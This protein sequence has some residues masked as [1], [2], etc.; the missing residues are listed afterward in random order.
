MERAAVASWSRKGQERAFQNKAN[1]LFTEAMKT[2]SARLSRQLS[3]PLFSSFLSRRWSLI[4]QEVTAP[5]LLSLSWNVSLNPTVRPL[6]LRRVRSFARSR[7]R[8]VIR[9]RFSPRWRPITFSSEP[10]RTERIYRVLAFEE[11]SISELIQSD[12]SGRSQIHRYQ[13]NI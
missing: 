8:P 6:V 13:Q 4:E 2:W 5:D 9:C 1:P 7:R 11:V 12:K 10:Q 3:E